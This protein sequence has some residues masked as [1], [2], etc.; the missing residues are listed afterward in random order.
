MRLDAA[1][2]RRD[3]SYERRL[4]GVAEVTGAPVSLAGTSSTL[5]ASVQ[6]PR[7]CY[8]MSRS[9]IIRALQGLAPSS[10]DIIAELVIGRES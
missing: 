5:K 9:L 10:E 1:T 4:A 2:R 3:R 7:G 8:S 6:Q